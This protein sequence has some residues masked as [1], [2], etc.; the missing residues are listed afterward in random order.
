MDKM[1]VKIAKLLSMAQDLGDTP[2]GNT[3]R[4]RA[5]DLA[6][7]YGI[8]AGEIPDSDDVGKA[9]S[10]KII[11]R[12]YEMA[13]TYTDMQAALLCSVAQ[14]LHCY[15][16]RWR[17]AHSTRVSEVGVF[18]RRKHVDRV[19]MLYGILNP[20]MIAGAA[21]YATRNVVMSSVSTVKRT[22]M[23]YFSAGV[24]SRLSAAETR[25]ADGHATAG[26]SGEVVL[27]DDAAQAEAFALG[28]VNGVSA[29]R[30]SNPKLDPAAA[31]AG[32]S[33]GESVDLGQSHL[34]GHR[35][36]QA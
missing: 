28:Q 34:R 22:Y 36:L 1:R 9:S 14:A 26:K 30:R 31:M 3:Y 21:D 11:R 2:A 24:Q 12:Q 20:L 15:T 27:L 4:D 25:H 13:G 6:A 29:P 33:A 23:R 19:D 7:R 18:G 17:R 8:E 35:S 32:Y 16:L 10:G 5:F